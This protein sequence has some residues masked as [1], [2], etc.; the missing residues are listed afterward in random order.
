MSHYQV[1][2][3]RFRPQTFSEVLGQDNV[4]ETLKNALR[5]KRVAHAY[6]FTGCRGTGKTTLVRLFAKAINCH[7]LSEECEPCN[8]CPS[9]LDIA[10]SRSLDI[11]EIDGASNR[12]IDD[13]RQIND[14]IGY[15]STHGGYKIIII[16][17][18]HMLTKEAFNALLKTLEEP[19]ENVK[20]FFATTEP[21]KVIATITSRCQ[22][23]DLARIP[24]ESMSQK[25]TSI[26]EQ[27][28]ISISEDALKLITKVAEGS[29]RDAES[30][31]DQAICYGNET[32]TIETI[33]T[34]LGLL[35]IDIFAKID[36]AYQE[37]TTEA[38]FTLAEEIYNRG[39]DLTYFFEM[40]LDHYRHLLLL[41]YGITRE[42]AHLPKDSAEL[43]QQSKTIYSKYAL[44][45]LI[46]MLCS[47]LQTLGRAAFR[48]IDVEMTLLY[49][50]K[51]KKKIS[52]ESLIDKLSQIEQKLH[53]SPKQVEPVKERPIS[54]PN[55]ATNHSPQVSLEPPPP[56][57]QETK[58]QPAEHRIDTLLNFAAVELRGNLKRN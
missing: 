20:F 22:R 51:Q 49:I 38:A 53:Q 3:K 1:I 39:I 25:L 14:S 31:L 47:L 55:L 57:N 46:D 43:Y 40:L 23:F 33:Q 56:L 52:Y 58:P 54:Q 16:D 13:I 2:A 35:P 24:P 4:I 50:F 11:L 29:L 30:L 15:A 19:P 37:E 7:H 6:L 10:S 48:K 36:Q 21:H 18:V 12:G 41:H 9:C 34:M 42:L 17:E 32:I 27:L 44:E 8:S 26:A 5:M 28:N 45:T